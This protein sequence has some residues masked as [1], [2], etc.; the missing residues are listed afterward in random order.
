[1]LDAS[2]VGAVLAP[3]GDSSEFV[4]VGETLDSL[5]PQAAAVVGNGVVANGEAENTPPDN[6]QILPLDDVFEND[7]AQLT[8]S[9]DDPDFEDTH[10]VEIDWGDGTLAETINLGQ[11]ERFVRTSHQYLDD[12]PTGTPM[13]VNQVQITVTDSYCGEVSGSAPISVINVAPQIDSLLVTSPINENDVAELQLSFTDIGLLDTH[14]VEIDWGDGT[15][16]ETINLTGGERFVLTSHQYLDDNPTGTPLDVNMVQVT[17]TDD[18]MGVGTAM[19]SVTVNNVDPQITFLDVTPSINE[20]DVAELQL[21]FTDIGSLDT[22][23]VEI[24]WGDGT[25][26]ETINLTGGERFVLTSHQYLD[27]IPFVT[28]LD[29]EFS[30]GVTV[31]DDDTGQGVAEATVLV[32]NVSPTLGPLIATNVNSEGE[33]TL[34]LTFERP[35]TEPFFVEGEFPFT[36]LV[37]WGDELGFVEEEAQSGPTPKTFVIIHKYDGPPDP[38]NPAADITIRVKISNVDDDDDNPRCNG[39]INPDPIEISI[40]GLGLGPDDD[41]EDD[42]PFRI[43]TVSLVPQRFRRDARNNLLLDV[44]NSAEASLQGADLR[45]VS[46]DSKATTESILELRVIDSYG[47]EG[48]GIRLKL[49]VLNN[50][51][52]LFLT[53]PDNHYAIYLIRIETATERL[54]IEVYVRNGKVIDPSDDSEGTR[55]RPPTD[56]AVRDQVEQTLEKTEKRPDG[57]MDTSLDTEEIRR[58]LEAKMEPGSETHIEPVAEPDDRG[59]TLSPRGLMPMAAGLVATRSIGSWAQQV[60]R[61]VAQAGPKKWRELRQRSRKKAEKPPSWSFFDR[62]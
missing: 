18:D 51:P 7:F 6:L 46:T 41:D 43:D 32:K 39:E 24:D 15:P 34:T 61:A 48:E 21:S 44:S 12:N 31:T 13:D 62:R 19:A 45:A 3:L 50:L 9:F 49:E 23:T 29:C 47:V 22:H 56:E 58:A 30:I 10:T 36:V 5:P 14:T 33:T 8:F 57:S 37:D 17:I 60:D 25:P 16:T 4:Q 53:L 1:M 52:N 27:G 54:V 11:G 59:A 40:P 26:T 2:A 35:G 42:E 38:L 28:P 20:N 55:D